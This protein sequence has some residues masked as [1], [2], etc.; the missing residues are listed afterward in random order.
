LRQI[1]RNISVNRFYGKSSSI[2]FVK[3]VMDA[4]MEATGENSDN[5]QSFQRP[6]FWHVRTWELAADIFVPQLFPEPQLMNTLIDIFFSEINILIPLLHEIQFRRDVAAGLHLYDQK[7]GALVLTVCA[8]GAKYSND[9]RVFPPKRTPPR[10]RKRP[11]RW[12]LLYE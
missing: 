5:I 1:T 10:C 6:E 9:P 11:L 3:S 2:I 12:G 8:L 7:F 4:K